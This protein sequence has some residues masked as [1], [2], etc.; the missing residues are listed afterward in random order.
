ME[1]P[2]PLSTSSSTSQA[3]ASSPAGRRSLA[4]SSGVGRVGAGSKPKPEA[5]T[6]K[7]KST[8]LTQDRS[9]SPQEGQEDGP[10]GWRA[11]LKP[12]DRRSPAERTLK[13]KEPRALAEPRAGEAP[14]KVSGSFAGSVHITLTPVRPDRTPR[15]ASPGPSLPGTAGRDPGAPGCLA[16]PP[17][18]V[19]VP[20]LDL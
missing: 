5:P 20:G 1:P 15:P 14:R 11:N 17:P 16:G 7:G 4:E 3:S 12:V 9:A 8:T 18:C 2:A 6:A 10:A 13:P 19:G